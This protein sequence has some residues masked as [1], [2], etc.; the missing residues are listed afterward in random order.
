ML[1]L[2]YKYSQLNFGT[3]ISNGNRIYTV[4]A[5]LPSS[6]ACYYVFVGSTRLV[7]K[8]YGFTS[9]YGVPLCAVESVHVFIALV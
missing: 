6:T 3:S 9:C 5:E 4:F 8:V 1:M 7:G 2:T